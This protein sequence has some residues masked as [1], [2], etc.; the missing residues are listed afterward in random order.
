VA[1]VKAALAAAYEPAFCF[2]RVDLDRPGPQYTVDTLTILRETFPASEL[3]LLIGADSLADLPKWR[4][5]AKIVALARLAVL[6]RPGYRPDLDAVTENLSRVGQP[7]AVSELRQRLDWLTGPSLDV[8][9][10]ELRARARRGLPLRYLVPPAVE[11]YV[12][13]HA[14]YDVDES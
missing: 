5:P 13:E 9:S 10:T 7:D 14:L 1:L 12:R 6:A 8:S 4:A 11:M 3:W 2:S